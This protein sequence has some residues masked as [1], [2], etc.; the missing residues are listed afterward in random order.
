VGERLLV[1]VN[2]RYEWS[3]LYAFLT[4]PKTGELH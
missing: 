2:Q 4:R 1:K 3:Y